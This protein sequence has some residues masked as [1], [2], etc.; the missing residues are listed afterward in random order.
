MKICFIQSSSEI[1]HIKKKLGFIP[2]VIPLSLEV[3]VHCDIE[4]IEYLDPENL[5]KKDFYSIANNDCAQSLQ[6]LNLGQINFDFIKNEIR[7]I[8]RFKFY[9][10]AFLIEII[11]NIKSKH[12]I[13]EV[14]ITDKFSSPEYTVMMTYPGNNFTN[15]ENI[16]L[17]LFKEYNVKILNFNKKKKNINY[18]ICS[19]YKIDGLRY[20][21][22]SK[23]LFNNSAYNL[24]DLSFIY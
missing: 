24:D 5:I 19:L 9:Q 6:K 11:D 2:I 18:N 4:K 7:S 1:E 20:K 13:S 16:F 21:N 15:I 23:I 17:D 3:L 8:I 12:N 14:Y 10:L 22:E